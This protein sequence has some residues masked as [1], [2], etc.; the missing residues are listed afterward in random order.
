MKV[1]FLSYDG[2]TDPLGQSQ[3]I[4]YLAGLAKEGYDITLVSFE[5]PDKFEKLGN[6][7]QSKLDKEKIRWKPLRFHSKPPLVSKWWDIQLMKR[8]ATALHKKEKFDLVHCRSYISADIGLD[9]KRKTGVKL[10]FDMRGFWADEKADGGRWNKKSL[11]WNRIYNYYKK[12]ERELITEADHI[13]TL[14]QAAKDEIQKWDYYSHSVPI[15]VVPCCADTQLFTLTDERQKAESRKKI[16][17]PQDVFVLGYLGSVGTWYMLDEMLE[18]FSRIILLY[19]DAVFL[20]ITNSDKAAILE[21]LSGHKLTEQNVKIINVNY[22][23]VPSYMK[24]SDVSI[25]FIRPVYS[26]IAS[27]PVKVGETICMGIPLIT[28]AI[29]DC[30]KIIRECN[31]GL[32]I[33]DFSPGFYD[34]VVPEIKKLQLLDKETI[35]ENAMQYYSLE[36]GVSKYAVVYNSLIGVKE[37]TFA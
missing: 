14:T 37:K 31:A 36:T 19:P 7:I 17:I 28:N 6:F 20:F 34:R 21:K 5:K 23:E 3:V 2:M 16:N 4:P 27:S 10:L 11:F 22:T 25:S 15:T 13:I 33:D 32:V 26:K 24:A 1:L 30:G 35:R 12:K 8:T 18:F 29:G 9:L